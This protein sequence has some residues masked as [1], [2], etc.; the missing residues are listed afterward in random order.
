MSGSTFE[1]GSNSCRP[2]AFVVGQSS[3][4][5]S[6]GTSRGCTCALETPKTSRAASR[7]LVSPCRITSIASPSSAILFLTSSTRSSLEPPASPSF[8]SSVVESRAPSASF[9]TL[10]QATPPARRRSGRSSLMARPWERPS[11]WSGMRAPPQ[12]RRRRRRR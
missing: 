6:L 12:G 2:T 10:P 3:S 11:G 1:H 5:S 9:W 8:T 7:S 4:R